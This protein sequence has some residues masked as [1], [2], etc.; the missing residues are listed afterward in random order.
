MAKATSQSASLPVKESLKTR[1]KPVYAIIAASVLLVIIAGIAAF[2]QSRA[3]NKVSKQAERLEQL[4]IE[5][6]NRTQALLE[7]VEKVELELAETKE[8]TGPEALEAQFIEYYEK[9]DKKTNTLIS[10][11]VAAAILVFAVVILG[12]VF[13]VLQSFKKI[14]YKLESS[15]GTQKI[16]SKK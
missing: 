8:K 15:Q 2:N 11:V 1:F 9:I 5:N 7:R 10:V 3:V 6:E 4:S 13:L 12:G 14:E 16:A